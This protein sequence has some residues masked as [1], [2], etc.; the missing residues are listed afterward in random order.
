MTPALGQL[1]PDHLDDVTRYDDFKIQLGPADCRTASQS[2]GGMTS[3]ITRLTI[4][5]DQW[6]AA[7]VKW[8]G[9]R[10]S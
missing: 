4:D 5:Q 3:Q 1:D 10:R 7:D 2:T 9:A 6:K 8:A